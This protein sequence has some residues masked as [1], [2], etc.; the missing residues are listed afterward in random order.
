MKNE[1]KLL[2]F[3][4]DKNMAKF[5]ALLRINLPFLKSVSRENR[6][7]PGF[8]FDFGSDFCSKLFNA[9]L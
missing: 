9:G 8:G 5:E 7:R 6:D 4:D 2:G 1:K 3:S